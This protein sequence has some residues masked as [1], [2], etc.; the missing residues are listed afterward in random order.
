MAWEF[1]IRIWRPASFEDLREWMAHYRELAR[2]G[3]SVIYQR[4]P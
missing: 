2:S 1:T 3:Q 4:V